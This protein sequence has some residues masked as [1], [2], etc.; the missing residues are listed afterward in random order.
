[1]G[2]RPSPIGGARHLGHAHDHERGGLSA[3]ELRV[4]ALES[5]MIEKRYVDR[6][7]LDAIVETYEIRIG[8]RNARA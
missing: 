7:A 1:M 3:I 2:S 5:L 8:P 6:A 4:R